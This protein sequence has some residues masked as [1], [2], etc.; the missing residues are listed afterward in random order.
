MLANTSARLFLYIFNMNS[1]IIVGWKEDY[2]ERRG[3]LYSLHSQHKHWLSCNDNT[4]E[5]KA[6]TET[7]I[8]TSIYPQIRSGAAQR[9]NVNKGWDRAEL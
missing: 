1:W 2:R 6:V 9:S 3:N 7:I 5:W 8:P 4:V